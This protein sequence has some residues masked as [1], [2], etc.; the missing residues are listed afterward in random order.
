MKDKNG[1]NTNICERC[2]RRGVPCSWTRLDHLAGAGF[3]VPL[4]GV[5]TRYDNRQPTGPLY[6]MV[7]KALFMQPVNTEATKTR[8]MPNPGFITPDAPAQLGVED[9]QDEDQDE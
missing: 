1:N 5:T 9:S 4:P 3:D 7:L 2:F 6:P 8:E